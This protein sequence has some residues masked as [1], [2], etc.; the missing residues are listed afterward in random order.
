MLGILALIAAALFAG[1]ALYVSVAEHPARMQLDIHA[2]LAE[3]Q[4]SYA[5]GAAMQA[6]LA[7]VAGLLGIAAGWTDTPRLLWILGAVVM[8]TNLPYTFLAIWG[9]NTR[10]KM[11]PIEQASPDTRALLDRWGRLHAVRTALGLGSTLLYAGA[12]A[13]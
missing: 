6:S 2:A 5:R 12:L 10:L 1:A 3:W 4:P 7:V 9:T 11:T 13:I 8:L